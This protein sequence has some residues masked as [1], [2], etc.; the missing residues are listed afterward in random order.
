MAVVI[1]DKRKSKDFVQKKLGL[2]KRLNML[3]RPLCANTTPGAKYSQCDCC[4]GI[5]LETSW[6]GGLSFLSRLAVVA[7]VCL[8]AGFASIDVALTMEVK[9]D[10][11]I[12]VGMLWALRAW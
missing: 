9:M 6:T 11:K 7:C 8:F 12:C 2:A 5:M 10:V 4:F 1:Q 3:C